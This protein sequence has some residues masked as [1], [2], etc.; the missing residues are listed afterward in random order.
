MKFIEFVE[1]NA[2]LQDETM[3]ANCT[4]PRSSPG[5]KQRDRKEEE[6]QVVLI[7]ENQESFLTSGKELN[8]LNNTKNW[9]IIR[10]TMPEGGRS[11]CEDSTSVSRPASSSSRCPC[12]SST[13]RI[14][15][16]C[17][18]TKDGKSS[19]SSTSPD[20]GSPA[21]NLRNN[22]EKGS[23]TPSRKE[24]TDPVKKCEKKKT[25]VVSKIVANKMQIIIRPKIKKKKKMTKSDY[26]EETMQA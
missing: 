6:H 1:P 9:N 7:A 17:G 26:E 4:R 2:N 5:T 24:S 22:P 19:G 25:K 11:N 15:P 3:S 8:K 23:R 20:T 16:K 14:R 13:R 10:D 18:R 12:S 21:E